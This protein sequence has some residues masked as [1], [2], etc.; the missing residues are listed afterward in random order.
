MNILQNEYKWYGMFVILM[1]L[2]SLFVTV[3]IVNSKT[4]Y[5]EKMNAHFRRSKLLILEKLYSKRY[6]ATASFIEVVKRTEGR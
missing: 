4:I 5:G 3:F 6:R 2:Q 1:M